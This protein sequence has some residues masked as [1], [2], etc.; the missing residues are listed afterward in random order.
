MRQGAED[1]FNA[2]T[3]TTSLGMRRRRNCGP[4]V[5]PTCFARASSGR[6][7]A[8][9]QSAP[10]NRTARHCQLIERARRP[11]NTK[12]SALAAWTTPLQVSHSGRTALKQQ[13]CLD[14]RVLCRQRRQPRHPAL[15]LR[16][17]QRV[18]PRACCS[19]WMRSQVG[20]PWR[21]AARCRRQSATAAPAAARPRRRTSAGS[22]HQHS[23]KSVG[24]G[25]RGRD[26]AAAHPGMPP[27][28]SSC[29]AQAGSGEHGGQDSH[30]VGGVQGAVSK[31]GCP[32]LQ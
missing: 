17:A 18:S 3:T 30:A 22:V 8:P 1:H 24:S 12:H 7:T 31:V 23:R 29:H 5:S 20:A 14:R 27:C 28:G 15:K 4:R 10:L 19:T 21:S 16:H 9:R 26:A 13:A 25:S 32:Q 6:A 2:C 11:V